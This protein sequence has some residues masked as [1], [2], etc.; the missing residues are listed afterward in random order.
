M[1][2]IGGVTPILM[3]L[4]LGGVTPERQNGA[5]LSMG[6]QPFVEHFLAGLVKVIM[7]GITQGQGSRLDAAGRSKKI[8][9]LIMC[10]PSMYLA[11]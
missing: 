9:P 11:T 10:F 7:C 2:R 6:H 3:D 4:P 8:A 5:P 1:S